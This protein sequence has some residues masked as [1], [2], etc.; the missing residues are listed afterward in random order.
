MLFRSAD[1]LALVL[2][3]TTFAWAYKYLNGIDG[4]TATQS[5]VSLAGLGLLAFLGALPILTGSCAGILLAVTA[6]LAIYNWYPAELSLTSAGCQ[7]LGFLIGWLFILTAEE[8]AATCCLILSLYYLTEIIW[9]AILKFS[10]KQQH[11]IMENNTVY[12]QVNISGLSPA[13]IC[14]NIFKLD[15][16]LVIFAGFQIYA[17]NNYSIPSLGIILTLWFIAHLRNWQEPIR[18]FKELNQDLM[19]DIHDNVENFKK[20]MNK[21]D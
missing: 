10:R 15:A 6:A 14:E 13:N 11:Q 7:A 2:I 9:A 8:G 3:W 20:K 12:Y 5:V 18:S 21:D 4:L 16:M 19:K 17:P 1:R